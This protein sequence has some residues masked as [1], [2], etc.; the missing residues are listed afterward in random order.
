MLICTYCTKPQGQ[1][2]QMVRRAVSAGHRKV[3]EGCVPRLPPASEFGRALLQ[4]GAGED[5][6]DGLYFFGV[7]ANF[8]HRVELAEHHFAA[9]AAHQAL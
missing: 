8:A 4:L 7:D 1:N 3:F 9:G 2:A 5:F 6:V